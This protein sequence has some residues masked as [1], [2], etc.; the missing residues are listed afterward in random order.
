MA[1][2]TK[3][4]C[5]KLRRVLLFLMHTIDD[6]RVIGIEDIEML[7]TWIDVSY[8]VHPDMKSHTGVC[9]SYGLGIIDSGSMKQKLNSKSSTE[10]EVVGT[11][12]IGEY[13]FRGARI[14]FEEE[15]FA[16]RQSKCYSPREKLQDDLWSKV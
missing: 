14:C 8:A 3:Q 13:V 4:D 11:N 15:Y 1:K 10:S 2:A 5:R 7:H 6:D 12:D 9:I 16:S